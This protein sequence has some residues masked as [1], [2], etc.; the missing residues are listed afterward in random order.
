MKFTSIFAILILACTAL[1]INGCGTREHHDERFHAGTQDKEVKITEH[2][3][4]R[5]MAAVP[6]P[7][8]ENSVERAN[9][10]RRL[11]TFNKSDKISYIYLV[12][13]GKVM[14]FYPIKGKVSSVNS[15]LTTPEQLKCERGYQSIACTAV[16]SPD[17]DGSYGSNGDGIF[18]YT[19]EGIYVEWN[20]KYLLADQPLKLSTP[21]VLIRNLQNK[22]QIQNATATS[23]TPDKP[24]SGK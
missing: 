24:L 19:T 18:F 14:A 1:T 2:N 11:E 20:D 22:V 8:L 6:P 21:P 9:L 17:L 5:L 12:S 23:K 13:F 3:Q 7:S 16:A 4:I 15:L 10:K